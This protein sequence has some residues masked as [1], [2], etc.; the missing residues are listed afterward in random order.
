MKALR[1]IVEK[2]DNSGNQYFVFSCNVFHR[3]KNK[4]TM[5]K[6]SSFVNELRLSI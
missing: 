4:M 5:N 6:I 3:V 2:E 1:N